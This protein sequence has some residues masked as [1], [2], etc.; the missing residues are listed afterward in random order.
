MFTNPD[1]VSK[2]VVPGIRALRWERH[3]TVGASKTV[4]APCSGTLF[5]AGLRCR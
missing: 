4:R 2:K 3:Y 5:S 1:G